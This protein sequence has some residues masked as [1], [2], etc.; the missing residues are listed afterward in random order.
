MTYKCIISVTLKIK[1]TVIKEI[2][3]TE[4][5]TQGHLVSQK[6]LLRMQRGF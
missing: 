2:K 1:E 4:E 5:K 6:H 3:E